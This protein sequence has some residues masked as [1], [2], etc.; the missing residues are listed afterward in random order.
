M[1]N[2]LSSKP[3]KKDRP[4]STDELCTGP[5]VGKVI[6]GDD[7]DSLAINVDELKKVHPPKRPSVPKPSSTIMVRKARLKQSLEQNQP[8]GKSVTVA[9]PAPPDAPL[10]STPLVG[11]TG[12]QFDED[13]QVLTYTMLG[14]W[15]DFQQEAINR[16]DI[17]N[18]PP[19][20][21]Y[22]FGAGKVRPTT[23]GTK[24]EKKFSSHV[25][26]TRRQMMQRK[27]NNN[28]L[29]NMLNTSTDMLV[30]NQSEDYRGTQEDRYAI[31]RS[32]PSM[33]YGKGYRVGSEFWKQVEQIGDDET[34][35]K[36]SVVI[37]QQLKHIG[38]AIYI[39]NEMGIEWANTHRSASV[40]YPWQKSTYLQ[41]RTK[42]L[43]TVLH[44]LDPH[45]PYIDEL[46]VIGSNQP[47]HSSKFDMMSIVQEEEESEILDESM[48]ERDPLANIADVVPQP[49]FGPSLSI[50]GHTAQWNGSRAGVNGQVG[51]SCRVIFEANVGDR[52]TSHLNICNDGTTAI[53]FS[54]KKIPRPN[55]LGTKLAGQTQRFYFDT[56]SGVILP[57][58]TLK[59]P[60]IFKSPNAGIFT[61]TWELMTKPTLCGGAPIRVTLRGV[62]VE[63]DIYK[64]ARQ[65]IEQ[66]LAHREAVE[67][68]SRLLDEIL[69]GVRTPERARSPVDAYITEEEIF[70]RANQGMHFQDEVVQELKQIYAQLEEEEDW[71]LSLQSLQQVTQHI[72][73]VRINSSSN[74]STGNP[75]HCTGSKSCQFEDADQRDSLLQ[76][77]NTSIS[78]LSFPPMTPVKHAMYAAGY[79]LLCEMVDSIVGQANMI[80][81]ISW[82]FL[83]ES[84]SRIRHKR[85]SSSEDVFAEMEVVT[86]ELLEK[87]LR[88]GTTSETKADSKKGDKKDK[89]GAKLSETDRPN[90]T[91][92]SKLSAKKSGRGTST[93]SSQS[94]SALSETAAERTGTPASVDGLT[95]ENAADPVLEAKYR[96]KLFTQAYALV[97][98]AFDRMDMVFDDIKNC[99]IEVVAVKHVLLSYREQTNY[100]VT[101]LYQVLLL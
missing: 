71:D 34:G 19:F 1:S 38:K 30:M 74:Y 44:E 94:K 26:Q 63:D 69:E 36:L 18:L 32:I 17:E 64:E 14:S 79:Q 81:S 56:K 80:R 100:D 96:E 87:R 65:Q 84:L 93:P 57:G 16:G 3:S 82:F 53:Y 25:W 98:D 4:R 35:V 67:T 5:S 22:K 72:A 48:S 13:G 27:N 51:V 101:Y 62:A 45:Q 83:R 78:T 52:I 46:E 59:F 11:S 55:V 28:H 91:Q 58:D 21:A 49:I 92:R 66:E 8:V 70:G 73:L 97:V 20:S 47:Q 33:D 90:S 95:V 40:H 9:R 68:A 61:E 42:Q 76:T 60:F 41:D 10:V 31:D 85:K 99:G 29:S 54:W 7:I 39:K 77:L 89:R 23:K 86:K 43:Q 12:P 6:S 50:G 15:E 2:K 24:K 37:R 75:A 88:K